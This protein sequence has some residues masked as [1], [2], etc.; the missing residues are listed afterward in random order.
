MVVGESCATKFQTLRND[1]YHEPRRHHQI[2]VSAPHLM[3]ARVENP[4]IKTAQRASFLVRFVFSFTVESNIRNR[5]RTS[6]FRNDQTLDKG[7]PCAHVSCWVPSVYRISQDRLRE[8]RDISDTIKMYT[9]LADVASR[10]MLRS[11][12]YDMLHRPMQ[13]LEHFNQRTHT[14]TTLCND[15]LQSCSCF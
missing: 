9:E 7:K 10:V 12:T 14:M 15:L 4:T 8:K 2:G 13:S 5:S 1:S 11:S 3:R 6:L